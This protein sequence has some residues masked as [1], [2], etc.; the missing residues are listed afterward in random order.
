MTLYEPWRSTSVQSPLPMWTLL[1]L[2]HTVHQGT[3]YHKI[4]GRPFFLGVTKPSGG[5]RPH[6][7]PV[8]RNYLCTKVGDGE[9]CNVCMFSY[10]AAPILLCSY[11]VCLR[12]DCEVK[13][14]IYILRERSLGLVWSQTY[15]RCVSNGKR[16]DVCYDGPCCQRLRA[17]LARG[18]K[19]V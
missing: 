16:D 17:G 4:G 6:P 10:V 19:R 1:L 7:S 8:P 12:D 13:I 11:N 18:A 5:A 3:S 15:F 14:F 2:V 9:Y